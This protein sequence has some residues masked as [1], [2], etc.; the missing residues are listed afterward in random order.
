MKPKQGLT[1][2]SCKAHVVAMSLCK[3]QQ[4]PLDF[5][6]TFIAFGLMQ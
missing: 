5:N 1:Y 6:D 3:L 4:T 2:L